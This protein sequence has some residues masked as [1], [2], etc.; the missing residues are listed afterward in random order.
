M[1]LTTSR[2][3][4]CP[5][6]AVPGVFI[7][8]DLTCCLHAVLFLSFLSVV[9]RSHL[10]LSRSGTP[11]HHSS[12]FS[13][14]LYP[15]SLDS[16]DIVPHA[17][18]SAHHGVVPSRPS[19]NPEAAFMQSGRSS[20]QGIRLRRPQEHDS[21]SVRSRTSIRPQATTSRPSQRR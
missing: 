7:Q 12:S 14:S 15:S 6:T 9:L 1:L 20:A 4:T 16:G 3:S 11:R 2:C 17:S 13:S 19:K 21:L 10:S 8:Q 18:A 5:P